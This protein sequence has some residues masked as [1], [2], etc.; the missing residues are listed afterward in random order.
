M[1]RLRVHLGTWEVQLEDNVHVFTGHIENV[2]M[3]N[4]T[5]TLASPFLPDQCA[6]KHH[7]ATEEKPNLVSGVS[8][9]KST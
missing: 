1:G 5:V 8:G 9:A 7:N 6:V 2:Q 3:R 4:F